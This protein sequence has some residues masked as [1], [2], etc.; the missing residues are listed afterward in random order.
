MSGKTASCM[1]WLDS[2][3]FLSLT[4]D[5]QD[6]FETLNNIIEE[7]EAYVETLN[8]GEASTA[9]NLD[10]EAVY[11]EGQLRRPESTELTAYKNQFNDLMDDW[12]FTTDDYYLYELTLDTT[13]NRSI[14]KTTSVVYIV[15]AVL[16]LI[17]A[18]VVAVKY[19]L[20]KKIN[21]IKI[22]RE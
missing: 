3:A 14:V 4:I 11:F 8:S 7:T 10:T 12:G 16:F 5:N 6:D 9:G 15:F 13:A 21:G 18:I 19:H 20:Y 17:A 1:I 2:D 22:V